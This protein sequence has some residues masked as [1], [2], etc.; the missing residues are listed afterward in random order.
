[1]E[2]SRGRLGIRHN[3]VGE[4]QVIAEEILTS[5]QSKEILQP[6]LSSV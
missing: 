5:V 4:A 6:N 3:S 1:M 2:T